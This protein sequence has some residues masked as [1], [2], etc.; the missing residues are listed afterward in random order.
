[1]ATVGDQLK[2]PEVG[3]RR[4]DDTHSGLTYTGNWYTATS[5][6]YYKGSVRVT[7]KATDSNYVSFRFYGTKLRLIADSNSDR[8]SDNTITIDGITESFSEYGASGNVQQAIVYEKIGLPPAFHTVTIT[9]GRNRIN[10]IVDAVDIDETG[11]LNGYVLFAPEAGWKRYD[12][13]ISSFKYVGSFTNGVGA[14]AYNGYSNYTSTIGDKIVFDFE[15]T[16]LRLIGARYTNRSDLIEIYVDGKLL[17][18]HS[19]LGSELAQALQVEIVGLPKARH[20]VEVVNKSSGPTTTFMALDAVDID[21]TGRLLHPDEVTEI[22]FLK[23]GTRIRANYIT[24]SSGTVGRINNLGKETNDFIPVNGS[25]SPYGDFYFIMV[26]FVNGKIILI[27][28]RNIQHSLSWN[29][30]NTFG[31]SSVEG[32]TPPS[33]LVSFVPKMNSNN[34]PYGVASASSVYEDTDSYRAW[35]AFDKTSTGWLHTR[36]SV[37][38]AWIRYGMDIPKVL[39][40]YSIQVGIT[41]ST[42]SPT[43]WRVEGSNNNGATWEII[44]TKTGQSWSSNQKRIYTVPNNNKEFKD[45]RVIVTTNGGGAYARISEVDFFEDGDPILNAKLRLMSG[46]ESSTDEDNE[47][48]RYIVNFQIEG[49]IIEGSNDIWNWNNISSITSSA[50]SVNPANRVIR[51]GSHV[52]DFGDIAATN[53][54]ALSTGFRPIL[55]IEIEATNKHLIKHK[56]SYKKYQTESSEWNTISATLPSEDTFINDGMDDLSVLDRKKEDFIQ[57]MTANGSIGSGKLF[58]GSIDLKKY[59][60]ITNINVK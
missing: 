36:S 3:W 42:D 18:T 27:A 53:V 55:E 24:D 51:G 4:Y 16:K 9:V 59:F 50:Y 39:K 5:T 33:G 2:E 34:A 46:G 26:N 31:F 22:K 10:F 11:Y 60:E 57:N 47:W 30:L 19:Q 29:T 23:L 45:H 44:D 48:D 6:N 52:E 58:K 28:D 8:H 1:M 32:I 12:D 37:V 49:N 38:G 13:N 40:G 56:G 35:R 25:S 17:G 15:G 7:T 20:R 21:S 41:A 54:T 14:G 43:G